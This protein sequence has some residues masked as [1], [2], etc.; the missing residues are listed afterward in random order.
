MVSKCVS[1]GGEVGKVLY[2]VGIW[3]E[4]LKKK[5]PWNFLG[6]QER[7]SILREGHPW[8]KYIKVIKIY[9]ICSVLWDCYNKKNGVFISF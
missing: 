4:L 8:A 6:R 1:S 5:N 3:P 2:R 7:K 9:G